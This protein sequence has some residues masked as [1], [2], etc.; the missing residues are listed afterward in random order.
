MGEYGIVQGIQ[1][2][3]GWWSFGKEL[4]SQT[5]RSEFETLAVEQTFSIPYDQLHGAASDVDDKR[6]SVGE[7]DTVFDAQE[8]QPSF[9]CPADHPHP[10]P[11]RLHDECHE[12]AAV[13][14]F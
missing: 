4:L 5:N 6:R 10:Q 2:G 9:L 1:H 12:V 11:C 14:G 8:N 13:L 7:G 3:L